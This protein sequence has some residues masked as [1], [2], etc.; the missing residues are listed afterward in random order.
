MEKSKFAGCG[1]RKF[2]LM[3]RIFLPVCFFGR[4]EI[5]EID[6]PMLDAKDSI[7]NVQQ[8]SC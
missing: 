2:D 4:M 5:I 7:E 1:M 6:A 8:I 3:P